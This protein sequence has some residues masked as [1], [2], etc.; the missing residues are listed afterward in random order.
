[1]FAPLS[2]VHAGR[3]IAI[4]ISTLSEAHN[5]VKERNL[6]ELVFSNA[7]TDHFV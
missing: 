2:P 4:S 6:Q 1:M 5:G 7:G 3:P